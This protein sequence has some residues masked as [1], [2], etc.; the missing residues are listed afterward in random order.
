[1]LLIVVFLQVVVCAIIAL[2]LKNRL[3]AFAL[4]IFNGA[5]FLYS[6]LGIETYKLGNEYYLSYIVCMITLNVFFS[7]GDRL[8]CSIVK[9]RI[10]GE[11]R[12]GS[13][14]DYIIQEYKMYLK[15]ITVIYFIA[16]IGWLVYPEFNLK[17]IFSASNFLYSSSLE[18]TNLS[19]AKPIGKIF[20]TLTTVTLPFVMMYISR[21]NKKIYIILFFLFETYADY[22]M[23]H[24]SIGRLSVIKNILVV[25]MAF[26]FTETNRRKKY[27]Y[28]RLLVVAVFLSFVIYFVIEN[29]RSGH[30]ISFFDVSIGESIKHFIDS[31][32]YYPKHYPLAD[33]LHKKG[34][35][36]AI[37]F[38]GWLLTLPIPKVI[39]KIPFVDPYASII[40]R[41]FTYYYWGGHWG[42]ERG[43]AGML[44]SVMG[45]G[46]LVYG[47]KYAF[48]LII[49]FALFI[50][51]FLRYLLKIKEGTLVYCTALFHFFVSF[52]PGVQYALQYL[53]IFTGMLIIIAFLRLFMKKRVVLTPE[54]GHD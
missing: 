10:Y 19:V 9:E 8:C 30:S 44:L 29:W 22:L 34:V 26:Y 45:D 54:K 43:Y 11:I 50:G 20:S 36:P 4:I 42:H 35:Y 27:R 47:I 37:V 51:F 52:R 6:C 7:I 28:A 49:P 17:Y 53:N 25:C 48:I 32:F 21:N 1:M 33:L 40:Y 38:W 2:S 13:Y 24:G 15:W 46:I 39:F 14:S 41:V 12:Y 5:F 31:E 18:A 3:Q 23:G 16:R